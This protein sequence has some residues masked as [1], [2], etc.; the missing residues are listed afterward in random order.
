MSCHARWA[1]T[2][3]CVVVVALALGMPAGVFGTQTH[4]YVRGFGVPGS[5]AGELSL[6]E[7]N[8]DRAG[9]GVAVS[10]QAHD[11]Y[12]ADTGNRRVD[13]FAVDGAF[14]RAFGWGVLDG[15]AKLEACTRISGCRAGLSGSGPGEFETPVFVAVDNDSGSASYGD[16]YVG[17]TGDDLVTK[18]TAEGA[19]VESWGNNGSGGS[20]NGQLNGSPTELFDHGDLEQPFEGVAVDSAANLTVFGRFLSRMF[21][22]SQ[23]GSWTQSCTVPL[24]AGPGYQGIAVDRSGDVYVV[25]GA[26]RVQKVEP[27]CNA[28]GD[29]VLPTSGS[30]GVTGLAVDAESSDLYVDQ[31]GVLIEDIPLAGCV[32]GLRGCVASQLFG[33]GVLEGAAG[34]AIDAESGVVYGANALAGSIAVF[35]VAVAATPTPASEVKAR[36]A[37]LHGRVNPEGAELSRCRFEYGEGESYDHSVPCEESP[38]S[39]GTGS[40][41][42]EVQAKV[43]GLAGGTSYDFRL[44]ATNANGDVRSEGEPLSTLMIARIME[45]SSAE[46]EEE[47]G[48]GVSALLSAKINPEGIAG[49]SC[50]IQYG[51]STSY[52]STIPCEPAA[53]SGGAGTVVSVRLKGLSKATY[54]WRVLV[55]DENGVVEGADQTF[56]Y[57]AE[58]PVQRG[59]GN[60]AVRGEGVVNPDTGRAF[61]LALPDCRAYEMVTPT[62]KDGALVNHGGFVTPPSFADDGSRVMLKSLQCFHAPSS[63]VGIR[64]AEGEPYA[65]E[66][67]AVGWVT[68]TLAPSAASFSGNTRLAYNANT[69][70]VLFALPAVAPALE[71]FYVRRPDGTLQA[72]GPLSEATGPAALPSVQNDVIIGTS[73]FSHIVYESGLNGWPSFDE[74][75]G[76]GTTYEYAG[77]GQSRPVLVGVTGGAGNTSLIS[78]CGTMLGG[79]NTVRANQGSLSADGRTVYF[80][81]RACSTGTG[82]NAGVAVPAPALYARIDGSRTVPI[83]ASAPEP[84]CD[85]ACQQAPAGDAGF[86]GASADGSRVFFTDTRQLTNSASEDSHAGDSGNGCQSTAAVAS[87]CNLYEVECP[88]HCEDEAEKRLIDVSAPASGGEAPRVQSVMALSSDGSHV[89]FLAKGVLSEGVN[90]EGREPLEG[91]E[92]L[93]VYER[94]SEHPDGQLRFIATLSVDQD[95]E[96][97]ANVTPDGRFLVFRSHRGLT[98][99]VTHSEGPAQVYRYDAHSERLLRV[100]IG[101]QGFNDNGNDAQGDASF[102]RAQEGDA[103]N[104]ARRD[105]TM[106]DDGSYVFFQSPAGLTPGALNNRPVTGNPHALAENVYEWEAQG[107]GG[108]EQASG[109]VSL[110]SD[111]RDVIEGSRVP[112]AVRLLDVDVTGENVLFETADQLG[113]GD[114]DTQVDIYDAR[115]NGGFPAPVSPPPCEASEIPLAGVCRQ[116]GSTPSVFAAP[117]SLVFS[118]PGNTITE[119]RPVT[120]KPVARG[121]TRAQALK[122]A[123]A[124]CRGR[125]HAGGRARRVACERRARK[126]YGPVSKKKSKG[127]RSPGRGREGRKG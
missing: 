50:E 12:V 36:S 7:A 108:C 111:G 44:R 125:S 72:V 41:P 76:G 118:G 80:T 81:A 87:G 104:P 22:F 5:G 99:D 4:Y 95:P 31:A 109:C 77:S 24:A 114:T 97:S 38:S 17:D 51:T 127:A 64:E 73:D 3:V 119:T 56:V 90:A 21:G 28:L 101:E 9:S 47:A 20:A 42:V 69:G 59:C 92:N 45:A 83:S 88:N 103:Q 34:L 54:H 46:I 105:P 110:I 37:I 91:A 126:R 94:D 120:G 30:E 15:E 124:V 26:G 65:F 89:Y 86:E 66:R 67:T 2:V 82:V 62:S 71:Q 43:A 85:T 75:T 18:F 25:E 52:G 78:R 63:C 49:T 13:E 23:D 74:T 117:G 115:V 93:Y 8:I 32:P 58:T 16:V 123:L 84:Q 57:L 70:L 102:V 48:G 53:L 14:V 116:A 11:V 121:L 27:D 6:M 61:S 98:P 79:F 68:E 39:I 106:S 55:T 33:E 122:R 107:R 113:S 100:S 10:E 60:E 19:L 112:S 96:L 29:V 40:L 1:F 35:G